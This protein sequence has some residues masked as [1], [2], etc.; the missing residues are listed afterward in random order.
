MLGVHLVGVTCDWLGFQ[1]RLSFFY[2]HVFHLFLKIGKRHFSVTTHPR[3]PS[4][5]FSLS[6]HI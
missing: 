4:I 5:H 2:L 6:H 1:K 3:Y